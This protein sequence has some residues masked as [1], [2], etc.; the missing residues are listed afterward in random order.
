MKYT[1]MTIKKYLDGIRSKLAEFMAVPLGSLHVSISTGNRKIG[2]VMN[3]SIPPVL[4][5]G[6]CKECKNFCYDIKACVQY[7]NVRGARA[8][9]LAILRRDREKYFAEIDEKISRRRLHKFFRWHVAG[10]IVDSEYLA[11]MVRIARNHPDFVFWTYTKMYHIVNAFVAENGNDRGHA[12]PRN[13]SIMFSEWDGMPLDNPYHFP[14]FAVKMADGNRN[15]PAEY[16]DGLYKCP[17]NCDVCKEA[18][19]GCIVGENTYANEH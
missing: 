7:E 16:F 11:D 12:I 5:C 13:L 18:G 4:C 8:R 6:N 19:R 9:N 14:T 3:V 17:G 1:P 10:D 2:R 15:H